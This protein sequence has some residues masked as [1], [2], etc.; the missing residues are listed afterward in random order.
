MVFQ[1][2]ELAVNLSGVT[3]VVPG[4]AAAIVVVACLLPRGPDVSET[5]HCFNYGV[6]T[7]SIV[8]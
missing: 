1:L 7:R 8:S 5:Y 6:L 4:I 2:S 3:Y